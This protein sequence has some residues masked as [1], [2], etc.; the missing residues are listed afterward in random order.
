MHGKGNEG[1]VQPTMVGTPE[2]ALKQVSVA[3][4]LPD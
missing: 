4:E 2:L 1:T 3:K